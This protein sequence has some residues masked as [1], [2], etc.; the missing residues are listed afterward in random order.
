MKDFAKMEANASE[1]IKLLKALGNRYRLM[2][3]CMLQDGEMSVSKLNEL[4]PIP[5][6]SLSQHLAWLRKEEFVA[7]RRDAQTIFYSLS[8]REVTELIEVLYKLYCQDD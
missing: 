4:I 7:T 2:I 1:A 3:L 8:S 5:Q 6:S